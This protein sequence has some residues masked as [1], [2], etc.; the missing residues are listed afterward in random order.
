MR[1]DLCTKELVPGRIEYVLLREMQKAVREG[2]NPFQAPG[3]NL[4][5]LTGLTGLFGISDDQTY[6]YWRAKVMADTSDWGLCFAC[7]EAFRKA[8]KSG[9]LDRARPVVLKLANEFVREKNGTW[10]HQDWLN[11]LERVHKAGYSSLPDN[12]IGLLL[13]QEKPRF[14]KEG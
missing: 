9:P 13:E 14:H 4:S 6:Q 2:F 11:F 1:C 3:I 10:D 8:T 7:A 12:E 5:G